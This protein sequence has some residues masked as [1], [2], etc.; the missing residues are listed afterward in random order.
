MT[1]LPPDE[2][3]PSRRLKSTVRTVTELLQC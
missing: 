1:K 3:A 2:D